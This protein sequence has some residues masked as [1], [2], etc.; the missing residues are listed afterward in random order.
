MINHVHIYDGSVREH[1]NGEVSLLK[2]IEVWMLKSTS[3]DTALIYAWSR[4]YGEVI[5]DGQTACEFRFTFV[6]EFRAEVMLRAPMDKFSSEYPDE[7]FTIVYD[8]S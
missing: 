1:L 3:I 5:N 2:T 8:Q 6:D 7:F 4:F